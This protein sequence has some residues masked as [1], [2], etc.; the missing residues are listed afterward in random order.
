MTEKLKGIPETM[1]IP[2]W[3]KAAESKHPE[4]IIRDARAQD[5]INRIDYD[6]SGFD[7]S[8]LSQ[9]G[10]A[11]RT[12]I[13]DESVRNFLLNYPRAVVINLGAGLDTRYERLKGLDLDVWYE[14]DVPEAIEMRRLFFQESERNRFI[15]RSVFDFSWMD[16]IDPE[17]K[18]VLL[19]AEGLLMYFTEKE[20]RPLFGRLIECFPGAEMLAELLAPILVGKSKHHD[21]LKKIESRVEFKWGPLDSREMEN[22]RPGLKVLEEWNYYDYHKNRWKWFGRLGRLPVIRPRISNRI[23]RLRLG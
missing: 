21:S 6:F 14:L 10:V 16:E 15:A 23:V 13:L 11:V 22:W 19:I 1:L 8:W 2:L 20:L 12:K 3:A 9:V 7:Q 18:P 17:G 4:P 5:I